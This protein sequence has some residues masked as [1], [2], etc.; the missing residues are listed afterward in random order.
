MSTTSKVKTIIIM[1]P[2]ASGKTGLAVRLAGEIDGEIISADSRQVYKDM[3]IGSGKDL[4]EYG[5]I[6]YHLID[7][8]NAGTE[9]SVSDFQREA[10]KALH[11]ITSKNKH[12]IICG[13]TGHYIKAL[14]EDYEFSYPHSN[15]DL[16]GQLES[17]SRDELY[18]KIKD[19]DL[20]DKHHWES[21]SKRR[22]ARQ[23]EKAMSSG[24]KPPPLMDRF[25]DF[26]LPRIY[27][28][29]LNR[30]NLKEKINYRLNQR[31]KEGLVEEVQNLVK[32]GISFS[33]LERYGL[34]YKWISYYLQNKISHREMVDKLTIE[35]ARFAKRQMTFIRYIQKCGFDLIPVKNYESLVKDVFLWL[36]G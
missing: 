16:T 36:R 3:D 23:I 29:S 6:N 22:M 30:E 15:L 5:S 25:N 10:I 33:R 18:R 19:L 13:G 1:G 28:I 17:E 21:D 4:A 31:L 11:Q 26:Y 7:I 27:Y 2:T 24:V 34:E 14:L 8:V 35:I 32:S 9:F 12:P 20:W